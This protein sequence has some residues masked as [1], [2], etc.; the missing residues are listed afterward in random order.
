MSD[1]M[2]NEE[3]RLAYEALLEV[4]C[5]E[6][7]VSTKSHEGSNCPLDYG[8][9]LKYVKYPG[10]DYCTWE[11]CTFS[12]CE[13]D[14][15]THGCLAYA[16]K[17]YL[18]AEVRKKL[19]VVCSRCDLVV[20]DATLLHDVNMTDDDGEPLLIC[21]SCKEMLDRLCNKW[22]YDKTE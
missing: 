7:I 21:I 13:V 16:T 5:R 15:T 18:E 1:K 11:R 19:N 3:Y 10:E 17:K 2:E 22:F 12:E 4:A 9:T 6:L 20:E 8:C 14:P